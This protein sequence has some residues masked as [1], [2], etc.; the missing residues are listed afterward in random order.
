MGIIRPSNSSSE[1]LVVLQDDNTNVE[2]LQVRVLYYSG[3]SLGSSDERLKTNEGPSLGL[4]FVNRLDPFTGK[5]AE[6]SVDGMS[7]DD[8]KHWFLGAQTVEAAMTAEGLNP[9]DYRVTEDDANGY[10]V[11]AYTEM[12]PV[13][14]KS[15]QELSARLEALEAA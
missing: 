2:D 9:T 10:K 11:M 8:K 3:G 7:F 14:I 12:V 5:W 1:R 15:V 6:S 13:L 4:S